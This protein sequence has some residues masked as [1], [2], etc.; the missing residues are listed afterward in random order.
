MS[1]M[2]FMNSDISNLIRSVDFENNDVTN[3]TCPNSG[4]CLTNSSSDIAIRIRLFVYH[5]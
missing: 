1:V 2:A 4:K 5:N 3:T